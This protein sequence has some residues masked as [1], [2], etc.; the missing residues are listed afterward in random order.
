MADMTTSSSTET[1]AI[2][3]NDIFEKSSLINDEADS[4]PEINRAESTNGITDVDELPIELISLIDRS[5]MQFPDTDC[6]Y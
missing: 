2:F 5:V 4:R 1:N 6:Q 3:Q